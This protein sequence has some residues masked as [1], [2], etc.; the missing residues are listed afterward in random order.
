[1]T[2]AQFSNL[3]TLSPC[4]QIHATSLTKVAYCLLLKVPPSPLSADVINGSPQTQT[5]IDECS[6]IKDVLN[7]FIILKSE[8]LLRQ[9]FSR[10]V[11]IQ[12]QRDR[13]FEMWM[14]TIALD[15]DILKFQ[16]T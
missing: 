8:R 13:K 14:C 12:R 4:L 7:H 10:T 15:G 11:H 1:M 6:C 3:L 5:R 2:S 16:M 9:A